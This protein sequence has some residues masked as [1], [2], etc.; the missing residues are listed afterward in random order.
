[1]LAL[2]VS[3]CSSA[4]WVSIASPSGP[5]D[6][7]PAAGGRIHCQRGASADAAKSSLHSAMAVAAGGAAGTGLRAAEPGLAAGPGRGTSEGAPPA[8]TGQPSIQSIAS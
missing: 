6:Q 4:A 8:T 5:S 3:M 2:L 1:M 7:A